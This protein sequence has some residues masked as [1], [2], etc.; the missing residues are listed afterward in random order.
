VNVAS[1]LES[2]TREHD[3]WVVASDALMEAARAAADDDAPFEGF[4][5][6]SMQEIRGRERP[7]GVWAFI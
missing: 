1:R 5:R 3:A 7:I 2:L 6:L 4:R